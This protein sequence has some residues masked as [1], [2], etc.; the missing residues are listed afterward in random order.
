ML[1]LL[2]I[3]FI[4][5]YFYELAQDFYKHRW[6]YAIL[7]IVVYYAS[8]AVFGVILGVF[9][10]LLELNIN[11]DETFGINLL[12]IPIGL[13]GCYGFYIILKK[14]WQKNTDLVKN[15]IEDIG[16]TIE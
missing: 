3:Y 8:G 12:S 13:L 7:G 5:K 11:W 4:G 15:E 2:L 14:R 9:D 16:K 10:L 1:G 6:L